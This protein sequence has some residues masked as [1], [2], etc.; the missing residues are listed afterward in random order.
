MKTRVVR[1]V[2]ER[3][4]LDRGD[5][6]LLACSGGCDS[7]VMTHVLGGLCREL[8][9]TV[10]VASIDHGLREGSA[11]EVALVN[12]LADQV[13][14]PFF[15]RTLSLVPGPSL[16]AQAR[17][18]RYEALAD[19]ARE[20]GATKTAVGH[21]MDDQAETVLSRL[22][23]GSGLRGLAGVSPARDDGVVR[24]LID[25]RRAAVRAYALVHGLKFVEDPSNSETRF[26]RPR[27]RHQ[28]LPVLEK[29][30]PRVVEHLA[31]LADEVA[32]WTKWADTQI[33]SPTEL[34]LDWS[35]W[36]GH[37][38]RHV[39]LRGWIASV[40]GTA[41]RAKHLSD[42]EALNNERAS[43]LLREGWSVRLAGDRLQLAKGPVAQTR[44][45]RG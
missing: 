11:D 37:P 22:L 1:T 7:V 30:D 23:R 40:T 13:S 33:D 2:K 45:T 28:V 12:R 18:A 36:Q 44:S 31:A 43:V 41:P 4:L 10:A 35:R 26:E 6:V 39:A 14:A 20:A 32:R 17:Q 16:Q 34:S 3:A 27:I 21:T 15:S 29:E 19:I 5:H 25:C 8:G 9:V 42:I 38:L 24:P